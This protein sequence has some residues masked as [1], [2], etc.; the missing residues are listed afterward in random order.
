MS[1]LT[2]VLD[3]D[4]RSG[5]DLDDEPY[6]KCQKCGHHRYPGS[7]GGRFERHGEPPIDTQSAGGIGSGG[8]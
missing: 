4:W 1:K 7:G 6:E 2:C 8:R 5:K 3:Y